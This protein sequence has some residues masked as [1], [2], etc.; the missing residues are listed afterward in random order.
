MEPGN[1]E[2][3]TG[4]LIMELSYRGNHFIRET[5]AK[6]GNP[7]LRETKVNHGTLLDRKTQWDY[8]N[9]EGHEYQGL[10]L[11]QDGMQAPRAP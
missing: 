1:D 2:A 4:K 6:R 9:Q 5:R 11:M 7:F 8:R 10:Q 3:A